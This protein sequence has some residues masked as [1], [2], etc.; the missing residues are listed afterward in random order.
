MGHKGCVVK[1]DDE[2]QC[3]TCHKLVRHSNMS[4]HGR[5]HGIT[6]KKRLNKFTARCVRLTMKDRRRD[7]DFDNWDDPAQPR[8]HDPDQHRH[9]THGGGQLRRGRPPPLPWTCPVHLWRPLHPSPPPPRLPP[10]W[11]QTQDPL[12]TPTRTLTPT[13]IMTSR[14]PAGRTVR[15]NPPT[16]TEATMPLD[17]TVYQRK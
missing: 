3:G 17:W 2:V 11:V 12:T 14:R 9:G 8:P 6:D 15:R 4:R 5:T 13:Q 16:L 10:P 7:I 1:Q